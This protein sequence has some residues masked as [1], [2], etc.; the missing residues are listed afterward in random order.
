MGKLVIYQH[1]THAVYV[2]E[3]LKGKHRQHCLCFRC[4]NFK[5]TQP[6]LNCRIA[7]VLFNFCRLTGLVTPVYECPCL[8]VSED[9]SK[10]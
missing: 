6:E 9:D 2:D 4:G 5:P 1:H 8:E 10:T 3:S 7:E